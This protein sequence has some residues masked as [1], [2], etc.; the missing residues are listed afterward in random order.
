MTVPSAGSVDATAV[1][2]SAYGPLIDRLWFRQIDSR[3]APNRVGDLVCLTRAG[4]KFTLAECGKGKPRVASGYKDRRGALSLLARAFPGHVVGLG[5]LALLCGGLPAVFAVLVARLIVTLPAAAAAD[6]DSHEGIVVI[7]VMV[8]VVLVAQELVSSGYEVARWAFYRRYEEYLLARV[9]RQILNA[10]L[11]MF[12]TPLLAGKADRAVR[13]AALEPGDLVDGYTTKWL[14][15][16][17]GLA[18]TV[19][20]ATVW[21]L[22][23]VAIALVW[24]AV[25]RRCSGQRATD[26]R[27]YPRPGCAS[28]RLLPAGR[29]RQ[30]VGERGPHLW[31]G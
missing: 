27:G 10:P 19:L 9:M 29:G 28:R 1:E 8:G 2:R 18:A 6:P 5:L 12:E 11:R 15:G 25:G 17:R 24:W 22:A 16:A 3:L 23:A 21:P 14:I 26:R 7:L 30:R 31:S 13:I 4:R 20:V